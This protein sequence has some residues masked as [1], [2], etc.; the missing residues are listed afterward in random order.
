MQKLGKKERSEL[1]GPVPATDV[2]LR[3]VQGNDPISSLCAPRESAP[4]AFR[5]GCF[6]G[7]AHRSYKLAWRPWLIAFLLS[8]PSIP[9]LQVLALRHDLRKST[10]ASPSPS[11]FSTIGPLRESPLVPRHQDIKPPGTCFTSLTPTPAR[12]L[13]PHTTFRIRKVLAATAV[14]DNLSYALP[15]FTPRVR[16]AQ[17]AKALASGRWAEFRPRVYQ[18]CIDLRHP[19]D[20]TIWIP[21]LGTFLH[22]RTPT[23]RHPHGGG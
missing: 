18:G 16:P 8:F 1:Q 20:F 17:P 2:A 9:Y 3:F 23:A 12:S 6:I 5:V 14:S 13:N 11:V 7:P 22:T 19:I 21:S 15:T 10:E 4:C